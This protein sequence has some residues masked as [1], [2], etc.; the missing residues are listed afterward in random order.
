MKKIN[1]YVAV[2]L[3]FC[4]MTITSCS[5]DDMIPE[6]SQEQGDVT[7]FDQVKFLQ[8][9]IVRVDSLGGFVER[10]HGVPLSS[11][12]TTEVYIGVAD[13]AEAAEMFQNW[14]SPDTEIYQS[15]PS[16]VDMEVGLKDE[17][18]QLQETVYF[19]S[20]DENPTL[21]EVTF[22]K[23]SVIKYVSKVIFIKESAWPNNDESPYCIGDAVSI[24]YCIRE[25]GNGVSGLELGIYPE[26]KAAN[27]DYYYAEPSLAKVAS[28]ILRKDWNMF[29]MIFGNSLSKDEYYW[30]EETH[31]LGNY[32][33][34]LY[35]GDIDWFAFYRDKQPIR[36]KTF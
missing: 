4:T 24:G 8:N 27:C 28:S 6:M 14:L 17:N 15:V 22:V 12:D 26:R 19:K 1:F 9:S 20:I 10:I 21:A 35:D 23:G 25:A 30:I 32:A 16:A 7:T 5:S 31:P 33:I 3:V 13:L 11:I 34:R 29:E 2:I 36:I 18:G